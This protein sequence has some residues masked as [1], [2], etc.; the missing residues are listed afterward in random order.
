MGTTPEKWQQEIEVMA[1]NVK[2]STERL[3]RTESKL[4]RLGEYLG[5]NMNPG[6]PREPQVSP[7]GRTIIFPKGEVLFSKV[8]RTLQDN[9]VYRTVSVVVDGAEV[10]TLTVHR[11]QP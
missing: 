4:S 8:V 9:G 3:R 10:A 5:V 2:E 11:R 1:A 7:D 6:L